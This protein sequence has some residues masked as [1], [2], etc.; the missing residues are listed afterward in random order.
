M[1][2]LSLHS[3]FEYLSGQALWWGLTLLCLSAMIEYVFPPFPGDTVTVVGAVMIPAAGWP[4]PLVFAAVIVGSLLG[5]S[6]DWWAGD[7]V[8]R[9]RGSDSWFHRFLAR[10]S[11]APRLQALLERFERYGSVYIAL[12]RFIPAFR[13]FFFVAAGMAELRLWK[14][15]LFAAISAAAWNAALLSIGYFV[16]YQIDP[17]MGLVDRYTQVVWGLLGAGVAVWLGLKSWRR[18]REK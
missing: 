6:V 10:E 7:W 15:L 14:V 12:N 4:W 18:A 17:L 1:D 5:A 11:V 13:A 2:A 16:G 8:R 3:I 9:T